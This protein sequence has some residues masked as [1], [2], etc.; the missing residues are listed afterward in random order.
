MVVKKLIFLILLIITLGCSRNNTEEPDT[1][2]PTTGGCIECNAMQC[3]EGVCIEDKYEF[4][5]ISEM[6]DWER[7]NIIQ[8]RIN[9]L[10][11]PDAC[12]KILSTKGLLETCLEFPYLSDIFF[13]NDYQTGFNAL[14]H[15][16]NGY[17][18]L[19]K[20]PDL[21]NVLIEKYAGIGAEIPAIRLQS[22][23]SLGRFSFRLFVLEF[24][25]A[26]D[27]VVENFSKEQEKTLVLLSFE[28]KEIIN[29]N[30]DIFNSS[31]HAVARNLL[32]AKIVINDPCFEFESIEQKNEVLGFIQTPKYSNQQT[33]D[34]IEN[35]IYEKYK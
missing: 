6:N 13:Y 26:Q 19:L 8:E 9:C 1:E 34:Y 29:N 24:I 7:P 5:D 16:F 31:T 35:Y 2:N 15:E 33:A 3:N 25:L 12:L 17:S 11:I 28:N 21:I 20:R 4:P 18:E 32:Y 14:V 22:D 30:P 10:Q 27:I 23:I